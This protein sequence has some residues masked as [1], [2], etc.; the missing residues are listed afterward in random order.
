[1]MTHVGEVKMVDKYLFNVKT[2]ED[3]NQTLFLVQNH[4]KPH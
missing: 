1:M 3:N 4:N 2:S